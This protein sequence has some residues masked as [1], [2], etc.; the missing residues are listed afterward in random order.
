MPRNATDLVLKYL[1]G[2]FRDAAL[3]WMGVHGARIVRAW[4][5]E[6]ANVD[7][8]QNF[9]DLAFE[10]DRGELLHF[11]YEDFS[12]RCEAGTWYANP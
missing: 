5:T 2:A 12:L 11:E 1:V 10:T 8:R 7:I 3:D 4:P 9:L 6:L